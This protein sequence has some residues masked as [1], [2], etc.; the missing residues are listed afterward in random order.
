MRLQRN[1]NHKAN[2]TIEGY[3]DLGWYQYEHPRVLACRELGH[4]MKDGQIRSISNS[5]YMHRGTDEITVCDE[6]KYFYHVDMSD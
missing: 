6:C 3:D 2:F 5:L 1:P 4:S